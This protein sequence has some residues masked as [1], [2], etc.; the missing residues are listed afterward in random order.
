MLINLCHHHWHLLKDGTNGD[1]WEPIHHLIKLSCNEICLNEINF[2]YL[3]GAD[4]GTR[5]H[6]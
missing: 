6:K 4:M 2:N 1:I 3:S 5:Q